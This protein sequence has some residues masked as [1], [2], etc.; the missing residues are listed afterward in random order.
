MSHYTS[1]QAEMRG[2]RISE[3]VPGIFRIVIQL[4][5]PEVGSM[6]SYV[7]VDG[8]RNLIV[9]PG[10]AHSGC[11]EIM[12]KAIVDLGLDLEYTDFFI[13]HHHLDHFSSVSRFLSG[14]SCI[15]RFPSGSGLQP[16]H[17]DIII[18]C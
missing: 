11:Y 6:N 17:V 1:G 5:I 9:D 18:I 15:L 10:M 12:E 16:R 4:P 13:T 3:V 2:E 7:I 14:K 8:S